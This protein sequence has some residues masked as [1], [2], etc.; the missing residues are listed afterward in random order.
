[1]SKQMFKADG[2]QLIALIAMLCAVFMFATGD[3]LWGFV[4]FGVAA[5]MSIGGLFWSAHRQD[6]ADAAELKAPDA[7]ASGPKKD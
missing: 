7:M 3:T 4:F 6:R 5:F 1:M 2:N